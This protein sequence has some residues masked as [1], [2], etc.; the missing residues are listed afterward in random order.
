MGTGKMRFSFKA[1]LA[2]AFGIIILLSM[3]T[4]GMAYLKLTNMITTSEELVSRAGRMEKA[5][6]LEKSILLQVRAEKN[7]IVSTSQAE[8][9]RVPTE[10]GSIRTAAAKTKDEIYAAASETGKKL[11]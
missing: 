5:G 4:G 11:I 10:I 7:I 2:S 3:V 1:K 6:E 8:T 9:A